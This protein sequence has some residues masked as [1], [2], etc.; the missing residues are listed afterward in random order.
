VIDALVGYIMM[1]N[2]A[3]QAKRVE[4]AHNPEKARDM[5]SWLAKM[6]VKKN[7]KT[8]NPITL[9]R[10]AK[11]YAPALI[12]LRK[13][14]ESKIRLQFP[15]STPVEQADIALLGYDRT[16]QCASSRDYVERFGIIISK[17]AMPSM[18]DSE[19]RQRNEG[20]AEIARSG[21]DKDPV[22]KGLLDSDT[23]GTLQDVMNA[24]H[25]KATP[26]VP[27]KRPGT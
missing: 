3:G 22:L 14:I 23:L 1:G 17:V 24:L 19:L 15:T 26:A 21:L 8:G 2:N 12:I 9:G 27:S 13:K 20:F 5:A 16:K 18:S 4:R 25:K 10:M 7:A 6:D 11:A